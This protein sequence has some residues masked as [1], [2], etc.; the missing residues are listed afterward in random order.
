LMGCQPAQYKARILLTTPPGELHGLGLLAVQVALTLNGADCFNMG[1]QAPVAEV[2]QAVRDW[3]IT[4]VAISASVVL[5]PDVAVIYLSELRHALPKA[6]TIWVGGEGFA[7]L[8]ASP[9]A[10]VRYFQ[11][12]SQAVKAWQKMTAREQTPVAPGPQVLR[13]H[14]EARVRGEASRAASV[15]QGLSPEALQ[16]TLYELHVHQIELEMQNDELRQTQDRL[17]AERQ[18]YFELYDLAPVGYCTV[19]PSG[20]V[21]KANLTFAGMLGLAK[22]TFYGQALSRFILAQDQD[23]FNLLLIR[24]MRTQEAQECDVRLVIADGA[25]KW[26]HMQAIVI[27]N[28]AEGWRLRLALSDITELKKVQK[29]LADSEL[30]YR[31]LTEVAP[32]PLLVHDGK[33]VIYVNPAAIR[34]F[35]ARSA[36]DLL[37]TEIFSRIHPDFTEISRQRVKSS[38]EQV[39]TLTKYENRLL[40]LDGSTLVVEVQSA[41]IIY[42][43]APAIQ[44]AMNDVTEH[45]DFEKRQL[46]AIENER[47]RISREVHDQVGQVFTAVKLILQS[48]PRNALPKAQ[49]SDIM[50]ALEMGI[51]ATRKI[52]AELRPRL[53]DDLGLAAALNHLCEQMLGV[54]NLSFDLDVGAQEALDPS[55]ALTLFRITQ[56]ALTNVLN[57]AAAEHVIISGQRGTNEYVL[58]IKDDGRGL[59][60]GS[61]RADAMGLITMQERARTMGGRCTI[62]SKPN[63]GTLV[64]VV[65]PL[66]GTH[67]HEP[68]AG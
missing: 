47:K 12:T 53:L 33:Q 37:Q 46:G 64:E 51:A 35:G 1:L 30:R 26:V 11:S 60:P 17:D 49:A 61:A 40:K 23:A 2:V 42:D 45:R 20:L 21:L 29:D 58:R 27:G 6:R 36:A 15:E 63:Q 44:V 34:M 28:E 56:E 43:G 22:T 38:I 16:Q 68:A 10:G 9:V 62:D 54:M 18:R 59:M 39:G 3:D 55:Q 8:S 50:Q 52:T 25:H 13:R 32:A 5:R 57:H 67:D 19:S 66:N 41:S 24:I 48:L 4:L 7:W 14:A 31:T 65:L